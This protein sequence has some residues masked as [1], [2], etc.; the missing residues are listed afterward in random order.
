MAGVW[1]ERYAGEEY[2][3]GTEPNAFLVTQRSLLKPGMSCL[4]VADGEGRNGVWLA[5]QGLDVLAVDSSSVALE[6]ARKLAQQRGVTA[7]FEQVDLT[8]WNWGEERFDVVAAIFIQ[9]AAPDLREQMFA[10]IKRCLKPGGLLLLHGYTPRQLEY[11]TGGPSQAENLYTE[12]LLRKAFSDMEIL[13]LREHDDV[14]REG[15]GHSGMS[16]LIDMV[17][18]KPR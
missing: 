16:A 12:A 9:F 17:A 3:F 10:H 6:K 11:K 18:R 4:A 2:H 7:K 8:Q 1:D 14:I 15:T 13:H 5:Q